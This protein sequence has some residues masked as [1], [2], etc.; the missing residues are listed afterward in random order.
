MEMVFASRSV[1]SLDPLFWMGMV[2]CPP[3]LNTLCSE[4]VD[5]SA[6]MLREK[7]KA[8]DRIVKVTQ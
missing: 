7:N 4:S 2:S 8:H 5:M 1:N 6:G 3:I